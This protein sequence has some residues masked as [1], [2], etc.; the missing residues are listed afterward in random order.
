[1]TE[2]AEDRKVR[3]GEDDRP[4][5]SLSKATFLLLVFDREMDC[6]DRA[7]FTFGDAALLRNCCTDLTDRGVVVEALQLAVLAGVIKLLWRGSL[8]YNRS[9]TES[10]LADLGVDTE[11]PAAAAAAASALRCCCRRTRCASPGAT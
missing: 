11:L 7:V 1:M 2:A 9:N 3:C 5:C 6:T 8:R 4:L 10:V